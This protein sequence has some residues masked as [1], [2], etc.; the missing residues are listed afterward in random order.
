MTRSK[1]KAATALVVALAAA[2]L[3]GCER[4]AAPAQT[5]TA[6]AAPPPALAGGLGLPAKIDPQT[7]PATRSAVLDRQD[8]RVNGEPACA[9][10][11]RYA[12]AIAQPVTWRGETCGVLT[13]RFVGM[14]TL[15]SLRQADTL[16][17]EAA[18]DMTQ[19]PGAEALYIEGQAA[20]ALYPEDT[21]GHIY[22]VPLAD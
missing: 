21:T 4:A 15:R 17:E 18:S 6:A 8:I 7:A 19:A 5:E 1:S 12:G 22:K 2:L 13:I 20:S 11:V 9:L 3:A 10:T 16:P 14:D